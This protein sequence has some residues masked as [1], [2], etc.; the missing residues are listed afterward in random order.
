MQFADVANDSTLDHVSTPKSGLVR[1]LLG[2]WLLARH[3]FACGARPWLGIATTVTSVLVA[4]FLHFHILRPDLWRSGDVYAALPLASE[5]AR[6]PMSLFLPTA[7]LPLW[8]ACLQL[9]VVIG[10]GELIL[11]RWLTIVVA[12]VGHVGSTLIARFLLESVHG[13]VL[14]LVPALAHGID[15]GPSAATAAVGACLLVSTRMNRCALLLS[16]SL[17]VAALITRGVDGV[18]HTAAILIGG[19]AGVADYVVISRFSASR[20][21]ASPGLWSAYFSRLLRVTR[22]LRRAVM[23]QRVPTD[24]G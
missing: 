10:L 20:E 21:P 8:A 24:A 19:A 13:H 23:G 18:E 17:I 14:G 2:L 9:L 7:Y 12:L 5:L 6:L 22:S 15:T 11:G 1:E 3:R 4:T 16:V